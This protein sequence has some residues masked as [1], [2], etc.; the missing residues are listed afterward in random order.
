MEERWICPNDETVNTGEL[1]LI[2]GMTRQEARART[3]EVVF[4]PVPPK[5]PEEVFRPTPPKKPEPAFAPLRP[6]K[7]VPV[8]PAAVPAPPVKVV[9]VP[10]RP[11]P[12]RTPPV[13]PVLVGG[14]RKR[15]EGWKT[16]LVLGISIVA[17]L[18]AAALVAVHLLRG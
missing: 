3:P 8:R 17:L 14:P 15:S 16:G 5:K 2:C 9:P 11:V 6:Q 1:C 4:K 18:T 10:V 7:P 13:K 12:V